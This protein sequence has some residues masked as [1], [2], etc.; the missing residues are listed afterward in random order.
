MKDYCFVVKFATGLFSEVYASCKTTA[1][2]L[3]QADQIQKGND[4]QH[5][6]DVYTID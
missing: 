2:I 1:M 3:A 4:Y 5:I 6:V